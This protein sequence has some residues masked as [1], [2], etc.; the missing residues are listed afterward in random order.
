[1]KARLVSAAVAVLFLAGCS[2]S[3]DTTSA[4]A[5]PSATQGGSVSATPDTSPSASATPTSDALACPPWTEDPDSSVSQI[6]PN[7]FAGACLGMTFDEATANGTA[8]TGDA[9]CPWFATPVADDGLGYFVN[10]VKR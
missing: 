9:Q 6:G 3:P 7:R 1:M 8:L 2:S 5:S 4:S 10:V